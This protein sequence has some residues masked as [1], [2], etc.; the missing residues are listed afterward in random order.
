MNLFK[1][2][3]TSQG[4]LLTFNERSR[5]LFSTAEKP[6]FVSEWASKGDK[7]LLRGLA[8]LSPILQEIDNSQID[9]IVLPFDFVAALSVIK[10]WCFGEQ[11]DKSH[12]FLIKKFSPLLNK[13]NHQQSYYK[14]N[15][16]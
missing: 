12:F 5:R 7:D 14:C 1:F 3:L 16:H 8:A 4:V 9:H 11:K 6:L 2:E 13:M 15:V 10:V